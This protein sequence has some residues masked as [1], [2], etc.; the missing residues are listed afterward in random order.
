M[1]KNYVLKKATKSSKRD[2]IVIEESTLTKFF[3]R[4]YFF[5]IYKETVN[6]EIT[7][8]YV[9]KIKKWVQ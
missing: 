3:Y 8:Y 7:P 9:S 5:L 1:P 4:I 2:Y 6:T